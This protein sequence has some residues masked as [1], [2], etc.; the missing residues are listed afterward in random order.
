MGLQHRKG[1]IAVGLDADL[2]VVDLDAHYSYNRE[3]VRS[4]AGFSIYEGRTF[5]G[6]VR[7]TIVRGRFVLRDGATVDTAVGTGRFVRRSLG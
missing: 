4:S 3:N 7:H 1:R 6:K 5:T 2:A